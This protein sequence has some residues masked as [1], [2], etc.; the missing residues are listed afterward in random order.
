MA[1]SPWSAMVGFDGI[2][3]TATSNPRLTTVTTPSDEMGRLA[4]AALVRAIREGS[5][6]EGRLLA[7]ELIVRESS[8]V[9]RE[10]SRVARDGGRAREASRARA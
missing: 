6:P 5:L 4:A 10:D 2:P 3:Y 1:S 7:P 9:V 8:R